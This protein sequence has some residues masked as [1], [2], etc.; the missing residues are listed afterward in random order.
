MELIENN[1]FVEGLDN[2]PSEA[3]NEG[4]NVDN[5]V[6]YMASTNPNE[7]LEQVMRARGESKTGLA[8]KMGWYIQQL[9]QRMVRGSVRADEFLKM[10]AVMNVKLRLIMKEDERPINPIPPDRKLRLMDEGSFY[11]TSSS[12]M[13]AHNYCAYGKKAYEEGGY[14][15]VL[16][17]DRDGRYFFADYNKDPEKDR[18]RSADFETALD[19]VLKYGRAIDG[20]TEYVD[21]NLVVDDAENKTEEI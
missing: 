3:Y 19:F 1:E 18:V 8:Q 9:S 15:T 17:R 7:I 2:F 14:L 20:S 11:F 10:L 13:I 5:E 12:E 6:N 4:V 21:L 16:C